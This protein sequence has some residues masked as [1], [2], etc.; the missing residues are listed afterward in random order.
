MTT[1][2]V[3]LELYLQCDDTLDNIF[4]EEFEVTDIISVLP[5]NRAIG[6]DSI[7]HKM[8]KSTMFTIC[9][10]LCLHA[11]NLSRLALELLPEISL[12]KFRPLPLPPRNL[13]GNVTVN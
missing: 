3:L 12:N 9:K 10:P 11:Q 2:K 6:P 7:S 1:G 4:I 8:L 5:V 13:Q